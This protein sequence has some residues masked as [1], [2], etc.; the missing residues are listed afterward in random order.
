[1]GRVGVGNVS[2]AG[3]SDHNCCCR[4]G[5]EEMGELCLFDAGNERRRMNEELEIY[6]ADLFWSGLSFERLTISSQ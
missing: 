4:K 2:L 6:E 5:S 1:M 3:P